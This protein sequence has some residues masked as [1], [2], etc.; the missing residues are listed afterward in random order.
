MEKDEAEWWRTLLGDFPQQD[1]GQGRGQ[2]LLLLYVKQGLVS[3]STTEH[4][5][6]K[7]SCRSCR[8][9]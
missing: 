1:A 6:V 8:R 7:L 5:E 4:C 2:G 3:K 9:R